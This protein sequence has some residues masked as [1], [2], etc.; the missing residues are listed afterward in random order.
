M[1]ERSPRKTRFAPKKTDRTRLV[2]GARRRV[3]YIDGLV[4][5]RCKL[6]EVECWDDVT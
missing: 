3:V 4:L 1:T 2:L 6:V 5:C